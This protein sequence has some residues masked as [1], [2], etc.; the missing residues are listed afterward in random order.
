MEV[1]SSFFGMALRCLNVLRTRLKTTLSWNF[2]TFCSCMNWLISRIF[3]STFFTKIPYDKESCSNWFR[4][5]AYARCCLRCWRHLKKIK[6]IDHRISEK[7]VSEIRPENSCIRYS[8]LTTGIGKTR[9][10]IP[11]KNKPN[12]NALKASRYS[13]PGGSARYA[14]H[15]WQ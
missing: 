14:L 9:Y 5:A 12:I 1:I 7:I 8:F 10:K 6:N 4:K 2:F 3:S 11:V 15:F 13:R